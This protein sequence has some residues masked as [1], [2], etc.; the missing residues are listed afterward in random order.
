M[1]KF[2]RGPGNE[3][4][5]EPIIVNIVFCKYGPKIDFTVFPRSHPTLKPTE[6]KKLDFSD[7]DH[8]E[9]SIRICLNPIFHII[10]TD[11]KLCEAYLFFLQNLCVYIEEV[12]FLKNITFLIDLKS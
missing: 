2:Q 10:N 7:F 11:V 12:F 4:P 6:I 1:A 3:T 5:R 9:S 8:G